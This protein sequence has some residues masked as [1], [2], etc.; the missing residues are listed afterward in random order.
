MKQKNKYR[1]TVYVI[2]SILGLSLLGMN[3]IKHNNYYESIDRN[4]FGFFSMLRYGLVDYPIETM[5]NFTSDMATMWDVRYENDSL[6]K[7]ID[8]SVHLESRV[9]VLETEIEDLKA[10]TDLHTLYSDM[11]LVNATVKSR[12]LETWDN[13]LTI[14]RGSDAGVS[15]GDGVITSKGIIGRVIETSPTQSII[16]LLVANDQYSKVS[17]QVKVAEG[18]YVQGIL[19]GYNHNERVF[20]VSL[21]DN[22]TSVTAGMEVSTAGIGGV[23]PSGLFVGV[24]D[25]VVNIPDGMGVKLKVKSNV[26]FS[27]IKYVSTVKQS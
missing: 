20:E 11:S 25:T 2:L 5:S 16:S 1:T 3:F 7:Q 10:L 17:V 18:T 6:R 14:D 22:S 15:V 12:P 24:V 8:A 9:S 27:N 19:N 26:D 13:A 23:Y 21:L 4:F